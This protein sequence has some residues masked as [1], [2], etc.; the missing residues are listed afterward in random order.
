MQ[1]YTGRVQQHV[2]LLGIV[3]LAMSAFN[4]VGG[5]FLLMLGNM[6][7]PHLREMKDVPSTCQSGF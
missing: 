2:R 4:A 6:L 1:S 7:F 3:W 5:I